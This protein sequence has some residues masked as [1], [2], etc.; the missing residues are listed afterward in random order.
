MKGPLLAALAAGSLAAI[1]F[2]GIAMAAESAD[3]SVPSLAVTATDAPDESGEEAGDAVSSPDP[4]ADDEESH[5]LTCVLVPIETVSEEPATDDA[6]PSIDELL[7]ANDIECSGTGNDRSS[8][9]ALL[10]RYLAHSDDYTGAEKGQAISAAAKGTSSKDEDAD[11]P[12][13][14]ETAD[15]S[16]ADSAG[17]GRSDEAH[18]ATGSAGNNRSR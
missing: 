6:T 11:E 17:P 12:E 7:A 1:A 5:G 13:S 14:D 8:E 3:P 18:G 15:P 9:V 10:A 4:G 16:P 2:G